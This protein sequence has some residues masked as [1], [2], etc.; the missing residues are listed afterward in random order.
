MQQKPIAG[1]GVCGHSGALAHASPYQK[2][3]VRSRI[4]TPKN[5]RQWSEACDSIYRTKAPRIRWLTGQACSMSMNGCKRRRPQAI[6]RSGC[7][8]FGVVPMFEILALP[9]LYTL[10][11]D[12]IEYPARDRSSASPCM[13]RHYVKPSIRPV[14]GQIVDATAV[15]ARVEARRLRFHADEKETVKAGGAPGHRQ[16]TARPVRRTSRG[17]RLV[18]TGR[19][20]MIRRP[21]VTPQPA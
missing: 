20:N 19:P 9:S 1:K 15:E 12:R 6:R 11:D 3:R 14:G 18:T 21:A 13:L 17:R 5:R 10:S 4:G 16:R 8:P 2:P 7:R